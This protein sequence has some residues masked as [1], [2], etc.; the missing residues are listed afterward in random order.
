[1]FD[2]SSIYLTW[3]ISLMES[4][5]NCQSKTHFSEVGQANHSQQLQ[6]KGF[7]VLLM[8]KKLTQSYKYKKYIKQ[9]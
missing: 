9:I 8:L 7:A 2:L 1:M 6:K 3:I 5:L 4:S